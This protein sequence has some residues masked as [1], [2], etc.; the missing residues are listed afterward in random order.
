MIVHVTSNFF[1]AFPR[2]LKMKNG[3]IMNFYEKLTQDSFNH[4]D[5]TTKNIILVHERE[6]IKNT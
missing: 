3:H 5:S 2:Y 1:K 4:I 6:T